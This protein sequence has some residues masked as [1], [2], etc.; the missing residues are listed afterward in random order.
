MI[1]LGFYYEKRQLSARPALVRLDWEA[2]EAEVTYSDGKTAT[3]PLKEPGYA[4]PMRLKSALR[5][6]FATGWEKPDGTWILVR[7]K[8]RSESS[9]FLREL[10]QAGW[11]VHL[12]EVVLS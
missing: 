9:N 2:Q 10:A 7:H 6:A 1:L 11:P 5:S 4:H 8:N 12:D 3:R